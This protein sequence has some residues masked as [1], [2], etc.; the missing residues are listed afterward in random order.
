MLKAVILILFSCDSVLGRVFSKCELVQELMELHNAT[1]HEAQGLTC[2]AEL[3]SRFDT[4]SYHENSYGIFNISCGLEETFGYCNISCTNFIDD[5]IEDD[6]LCARESSTY[7][8]CI[9]NSELTISDCG[10][11]ENM[12]NI[13]T[14]SRIFD[15]MLENGEELISNTNTDETSAESQK[16]STVHPAK[17]DFWPTT[18]AIPAQTSFYEIPVEV[19]KARSSD[20]E[21]SEKL[22]IIQYLL[23]FNTRANVRYIF[24]FV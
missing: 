21:N 23:N 5:H 15:V 7:D 14:S 24:L 18:E 3:S 12:E 20:D 4:R 1:L 22:Q 16:T 19:V 13:L 8:N 10:F 11:E 17:Q 2:V 9:S 6:Y